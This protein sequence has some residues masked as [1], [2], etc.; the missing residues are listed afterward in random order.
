[1]SKQKAPAPRRGMVLAVFGLLTACASIP[2]APVDHIDA[3]RMATVK[4]EVGRGHGSGVIVSPDYILTA[5]HVVDHALGQ[6]MT[7]LFTDGTSGLAALVW[8]DENRDVAIMK[9]VTPTRL[10]PAKL[11]HVPP[12]TGDTIF[13]AGYPL[14][15]PL[16]VQR[17]EIASEEPADKIIIVINCTIAPGDSGGPVFNEAGEVVGLNDL[18]FLE[19]MDDEGK[20]LA[21]AALNG[22]VGMQFIIADIHAQ[23]GI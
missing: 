10:P 14:G 2:T 4:L 15:L 12:H 5:A 17:G 20:V 22:M 11:S 16:S 19:P 6:P 21:P 7:V 9:L 3:M 23:T 8:E 1:M 13:S 18:Q